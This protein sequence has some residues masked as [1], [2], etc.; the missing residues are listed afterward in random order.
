MFQPYVESLRLCS[1]C[2]WME[3][4]IITDGGHVEKRMACWKAAAV[5]PR[6]VKGD[7]CITQERR[8]PSISRKGSSN[9]TPMDR[10]RS[11]SLGWKLARLSQCRTTS[12][13]AKASSAECQV[14][15]HSVAP[16]QHPRGLSLFSP[17]PPPW[18]SCGVRP[19][20]PW[21]SIE[22][23]VRITWGWVVGAS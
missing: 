9:N 18:L 13:H 3:S 15:N 6:T 2:R 21:C 10:N 14:S 8:V 1:C 5:A 23:S 12:K 11:K 20:V 7:W 19:K 22:I 16:S 4:L 17:F